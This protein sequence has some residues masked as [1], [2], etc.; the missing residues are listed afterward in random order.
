MDNQNKTETP[1]LNNHVS[2]ED[3]KKIR[4]GIAS[5]DVPSARAR[6]EKS[7]EDFPAPSM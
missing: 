5:P 2:A 4:G 3:L 6:V 7:D 1:R